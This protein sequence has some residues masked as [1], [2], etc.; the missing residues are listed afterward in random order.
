MVGS[1]FFKLADIANEPVEPAWGPIALA[2]VVSFVI[3]YA[4]IA[5]L[6]RYI[7][8]HDFL[9][10]VVYRIAWPWWW[11]CCC[12]PGSW[13]RC[14]VRRPFCGQN[15]P[16]AGRSARFRRAWTYYDGTPLASDSGPGGHGPRAPH[17]PAG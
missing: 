12:S 6:L 4:V 7:S 15:L 5:W 13:S 9:P 1:G 3:G 8:T 2:T 11:P 14:P 17:R 10:F 16:P